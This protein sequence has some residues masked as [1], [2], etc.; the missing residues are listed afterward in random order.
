MQQRLTVPLDAKKD[1]LLYAYEQIYKPVRDQIE[2]EG[3]PSSLWHLK[4]REPGWV[5]SKA[6]TYLKGAGYIP[7][8][9]YWNDPNYGSYTKPEPPNSFWKPALEALLADGKLV[10]EQVENRGLGKLGYM[11]VEMFEIR[12]KILK[13]MR[14]ER[15]QIQKQKD[16]CLDSISDLLGDSRL[17]DML[18]DLPL[19]TLEALADGVESAVSGI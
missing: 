7:Q 3:K 16:R 1:A 6:I 12:T 15:D 14:A 2:T 19:E 10:R 5:A 13:E 17:Y 8:N 9:Y 11:P 4:V 18:K